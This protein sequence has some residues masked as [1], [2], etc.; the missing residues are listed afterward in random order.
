MR[1]WLIRLHQALSNFHIEIVPA[2]IYQS[3][4]P[5]A[6]RDKF[7]NLRTKKKRLDINFAMMCAFL[8]LTSQFYRILMMCDSHAVT[9]CKMMW[10]ELTSHE[11]KSWIS[12][13]NFMSS[14]FFNQRHQSQG[15][16]QF[17][18]TILITF[19]AQ[20]HCHIYVLPLP[21]HP[22]H[23][24]VH[25]SQQNEKNVTEGLLRLSSSHLLFFSVIYL[26]SIAD[27]CRPSNG[28]K[29]IFLLLFTAENF[30]AEEQ[31]NFD[32]WW[33]FDDSFYCYIFPSSDVNN[34]RSV[35]YL[36]IFFHYFLSNFSPFSLS[37]ETK[38]TIML[39]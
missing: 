11:K 37:L 10:E 22:G 6:F 15:K 39:F 27:I 38:M 7:H 31:D 14:S 36:L 29:A 28:T 30:T 17:P 12:S 4:Q 26:T 34:K 32:F 21:Q 13:K 1:E 24:A 3:L 35:L 25:V 9:H 33:T 8:W 20:Q 16:S 23:L 18:T 2:I 19:N 5:C